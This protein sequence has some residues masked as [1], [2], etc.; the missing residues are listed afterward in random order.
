MN[1]NT[2][3]A[4]SPSKHEPVKPGSEIVWWRV[5]T[6]I[7]PTASRPLEEEAMNSSGR[8]SPDDGLLL[9]AFG[10]LSRRNLKSVAYQDRCLADLS[11]KGPHL[12]RQTG[13]T[14]AD[15]AVR[16]EHE[17]E[18]ILNAIHVALHVEE[19]NSCLRHQVSTHTARVN[20]WVLSG[21]R[22]HCSTRLAGRL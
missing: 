11:G 9:K 12:Q 22:R 13:V 15:S 10:T 19:G 5:W 4:S 1:T 6:T 7:P 16:P 2:T 20:P 3:R 21:W 8:K 18:L 14:E 17:G